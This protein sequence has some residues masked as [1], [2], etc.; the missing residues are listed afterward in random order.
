[1]TTILALGNQGGCAQAG[2][3]EEEARVGQSGRSHEGRGDSDR[4]PCRIRQLSGI[5][6]VIDD[7]GLNLCCTRS[8]GSIRPLTEI[9]TLKAIAEVDSR[10]R[11]YAC[12]TQVMVW[13][14]S[15]S[16][17]ILSVSR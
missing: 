2:K 5:R 7:G 9:A 11:A 15:P 3:A 16:P 10:G 17:S 6:S 13:I 8:T 1:M 12:S 4:L 14:A